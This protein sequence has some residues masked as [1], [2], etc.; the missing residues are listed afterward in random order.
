V[1]SR[2]WITVA[3]MAVV[4]CDNT[5][6]AGGSSAPTVP[7]A[8][9]MPG[10]QSL[11]PPASG[12][13][14]SVPVL[15]SDGLSTAVPVPSSAGI[16]TSNQGSETTSSISPL[17]RSTVVKVAPTT[18]DEVALTFD[19]D[20]PGGHGLEIVEWLALHRT[21]ATVFMTGDWTDN[22]SFGPL[23]LAVIEAH[24]E[25]F[26]LANHSYS[27]PHFT[28]LTPDQMRE[29]LWSAE[30]SIRR[31]CSQDPKPFWRPPYLE[32]DSTVV[33]VA[34]Q[35]GYRWTV[36]ADVTIGDWVPPDVRGPTAA[37]IVK[38]A[39]TKAKPG[40]II[41]LH[42]GGYNT[43]DA[44]PGIV[45]GLEGRGLRLVNLDEMFRP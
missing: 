39:V 2:F 20:S 12:L 24:P 15:P 31:Y 36:L 45:A 40:S 6:V 18:R 32:L 9:E 3:I 37:A 44:L 34:G 42:L 26:T 22:T 43:Y 8:T 33:E 5:G 27:H 14:T 1:G 28:T 29:E 16:P 4:A 35:Q 7:P 23:I 30:R 21:H 19:S 17:G 41:G 13:P 38:A 10:L 25:L 11:V